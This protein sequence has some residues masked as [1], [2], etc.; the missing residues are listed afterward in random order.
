MQISNPHPF[1]ISGRLVV[2]PPDVSGSASDPSLAYTLAPFETKQYPDFMASAG[3][4]GS[5]SVDVIAAV[6]SAP[7]TVTMVSAVQ[8]PQV[9]PASALS[10][11]SRGVLIA[12]ADPVHTR[13]NIGIRSLGQG[14]GMTI[15]VRNASGAE[16]RSV[17]RPFPANYF[18]QFS[19]ADLTGAPLGANDSI[20]ITIHA[21]SAIVYGAAIDNA[22]GNTT[23]QIA[24]KV[25]E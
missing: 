23:L 13:F 21:G 5:G 10:A 1:A 16:L 4:T 18:H 3:A 25:S 19:A 8:V 20:V 9:D 22:T 24:R 17:T 12:P 11:G 14:V 2:H 15:S 7:V 6:G